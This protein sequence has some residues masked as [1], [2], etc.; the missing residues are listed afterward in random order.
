MNN[1]LVRICEIKLTGFKNIN[2]GMVEMPSALRNAHFLRKADVLGIYG[3]NGSGKTAVIEAMDF[4]QRLLMGRSLSPDTVEY[5]GKERTHC[6]I[7]VTFALE[8]DEVQSK[9]IYAITFS[10]SEDNGFSISEESL[11][12]HLWNGEK[13]EP[14]KNLLCFNNTEENGHF[15]PE[16]RYKALMRVNEENK[17]NL[18][19]AQKLA[20]KEHCSVIFGKEG[21]QIFLS[22]PAEISADYREVIATLHRYACVNLFV[23]PNAHSGI[24][25][26]NLVLPFA[27]RLSSGKTITKGDLPI[28]LD[29]PSVITKEHYQI[30]RQILAE[31]NTVLTKMIPGLSIDI[32][33]FG[34][35]LLENGIAGHKIEL[36]SKQGDVCI[37]LKYESE[38]IIKIVS[39]L[40][41]LMCVFNDPSMCLMIDELD[42]G[43]YEYLLG[44]LLSVFAKGAKGQLLFTSHN[45]RAL[46]MLDK[47]SIVFSTI[48][49]EN[50]YMRLQHVKTNN[51]LRD[52]YLRSITLG[53]QKEEV[54]AETDTVEIGRAFRRAGKAV[55]DGS[56]Q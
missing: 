42:S 30:V 17:V 50:R 1:S 18:G 20:Q 25:S 6:S 47:T 35:Q 32:H 19:V 5:I 21:R 39:I 56:K 27:F 51:N 12:S 26:L 24:I 46:E 33:D 53:G 23:I 8:I 11:V 2:S 31:M 36:I 38:G 10:R 22:A 15:A 28:H 40:N 4:I 48:N 52:L 16:F 44:E 34:E 7:E 49:P 9:I 37:P 3:Q 14:K 43:I 41:V 55:R 45:L 13:F 54:Y 29:E